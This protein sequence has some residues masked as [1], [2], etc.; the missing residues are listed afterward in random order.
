MCG[1]PTNAVLTLAGTCTCNAGL[2]WDG[3]QCITP[4]ACSSAGKASYIETCTAAALPC[5]NK[6]Q[7]GIGNPVT[8]SL[9]TKVQRESVFVHPTLPLELIYNSREVGEAYP[10]LQ[11][12]FGANWTFRYG[13]RVMQLASG[14]AAV[15]R[16]DGKVFEFRPPTSGNTYQS[17]ADVADRLV[18]EVDAVNNFIG[19]I[20]SEAATEATETY[21]TDGQLV[22]I[23]Q[24]NGRILTLSYSDAT[25]AA[26]VAPKAGLLISVSDDSGRT[27]LFNYN[28]IG[29]IVNLTD[30]AGSRYIFAY[31][32]TSSIVQPGQAAGLNLTSIIFPDGKQRIYWYNEQANTGNANLPNS[33]TGITDENNAR[34]ATY[35]YDAQGRAIKEAHAPDSNL[36][37]DQYQLNYN[38]DGSGNPV[39]TAVTD[40]LGSVRTYNFQTIL[41]VVKSTGQSQP[42]GSGCGPAATNVTYDANG[43]IATRTDFN[44]NTTTY[45]YDLTRN[46]ETSR[47]EAVGTPQARTVTT[48]W[49]PTFR[50]PTQITEPGRV[51]KYSYDATTGN[52]LSKSITDTAS[53]ATRTWTYTYT[54]AGDNT[55]PALL[56]TA[57][58]PRSDVA[59]VT[60][61]DYYAN[62]DLKTVTNALGQATQITSYDPNG[63][64]LTLVDPNGLST[65]LSYTPRGWLASRTVGSETTG[66]DYDGVGQLTRVTFPDGSYVSYT[67]DD[68]HRLTDIFDA[69]GNHIHYTLDAMGN[70]TREDVYDSAGTLAQTK[71]RIFDALGRLWKEIGA[72]NQ[73]TQYT[74]DPNGNLISVTD[75]LNHTTVNAYDALNRLTQA[76]DA[77]SGV[78][79]YGYDP[80]DQLRSVT[81]PR[82]LVTQYV[83]NGLGDQTQL[84]SP[85]TGTTGKTYDA[86]GN[87]KT[88]TDARGITATYSYDALNRVTQIAYTGG[89]TLG[90]QYDQGANGIGRLTQMTDP[91]GTTSWT[92]NAQGRVASKTQIV[93]GVTQSLLYGYDTAGR[94]TSLTYPSGK[95]VSYGY[96]AQGQIAAITTDGVPL[97]SNVQYQP[98]GP[99]KSWT[100]GNGT[101]Y[102]RSFDTDGHLTS[103]PLANDS[104]TLSLD[105]AARITGYT[106]TQPVANQIFVYDNLDR[107]TSWIAPSTNQSY[108][109]DANGNRASLIIGATQYAN[110]VAATSNRLLSVGGPQARTYQYDATGNIT[111]DGRTNFGFDARG[112][113]TSVSNSGGSLGYLLNGLGQRVAKTGGNGNRFFYDEAGRLLGDYDPGGAL[114]E[115]T[116]YLG[117]I[118]VAVMR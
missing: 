71:T 81:D 91:A 17:D 83:V 99:A 28:Q 34:Y 25:T 64:P 100:W 15:S 3:E 36:G 19:W 59:D 97:L 54:G 40:P 31:D 63:R 114:L 111:N 5:K 47:T 85:D 80:L 16:P 74:Y 37:I 101:P 65:T 58:G 103:Y 106:D 110:T 22:S 13:T 57:D 51:T 1:C 66:Y 8:P 61:Y 108:G 112:R 33:L 49:H 86:A 24:R 38:V 48:Q 118:P 96:N 52:V 73:T 109:Y 9:G 2:L 41:G 42:G 30:P 107:L 14:K 11:Y 77:A 21:N 70:R 50:L 79:R 60:T 20:Y 94:L 102:S 69:L 93:G 7:C 95:V 90:F 92:Y 116:V 75:P 87:L 23:A 56:K 104:R 10:A 115:E 39:S 26:N 72:Y 76:T 45:Q 29:Q 113:L 32:G 12:P 46:L 105:A 98:F 35:W 4:S 43:N 55:L 44:G 53:G 68:A 84:V 88:S 89:L 78:T 27:L 6:G 18:R 62:G 82:N 117:D 67:Y